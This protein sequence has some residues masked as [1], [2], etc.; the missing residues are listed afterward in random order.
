VRNIGNPRIT[1]EN[2]SR[3]AHLMCERAAGVKVEARCR[4]VGSMI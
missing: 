3:F 2:L 4:A 1:A